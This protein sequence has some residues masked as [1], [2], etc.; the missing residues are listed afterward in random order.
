MILFQGSLKIGIA[1]LWSNPYDTNH[2][3]NRS[4]SIFE[5][6]SLHII[7]PSGKLT[8]QWKMGLLKMHS[9]L[10][11]GIFHCYVSLCECIGNGVVFLL[12]PFCLKFTLKTLN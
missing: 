10:K 11:M 1:T 2:T 9:L 7:L 6:K 4:S 5:M 3:S 12:R 8:W